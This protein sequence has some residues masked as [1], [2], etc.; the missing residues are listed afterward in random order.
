[1]GTVSFLTLEKI[2]VSYP[3]KC[4]DKNLK[5]ETGI[6]VQAKEFKDGI[7]IVEPKNKYE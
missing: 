1:M 5:L 7:F 4:V 2:L 3:A 6:I